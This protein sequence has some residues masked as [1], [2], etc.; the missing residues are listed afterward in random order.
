ME[1]IS[2]SQYLHSVQETIDGAIRLVTGN[3]NLFDIRKRCNNTL[4]YDFSRMVEYLAQPSVQK[5]LGVEGRSWV[6]CSQLVLN[7]FLHDMMLEVL[8]RVVLISP[9]LHVRFIFV[10]MLEMM[11]HDHEACGERG[12]VVL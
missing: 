10:L 6:G 3:I 12:S 4:C 11:V 2:R 9:F 5:A 7:D 8:C 1:I